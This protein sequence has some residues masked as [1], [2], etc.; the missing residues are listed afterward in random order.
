MANNMLEG[1]AL[2]TPRRTP[3][4]A[5]VTKCS[6][7][8]HQAG[9]SVGFNHTIAHAIHSMTLE[10]LHLFHPQATATNGIPTVN[11]DTNTGGIVDDAPEVVFSLHSG[12][13]VTPTMKG[14]N[15]LFSNLG[16]GTDGY[17]DAWSPVER[18]VHDFHMRDLW[19]AVHGI[20]ASRV[21]SHPPS[22][23]VCTCLLDTEHNGIRAAVQWVADQYKR[24]TPITLLG[25]SIP[26]LTD[27]A[28]WSI[29]R[30]R[31]THYYDEQS[32][33]DAATYMHC[34][35]WANLH[36]PEPVV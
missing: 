34:R 22:E 13:F 7:A 28:S 18:I 29:W 17:S 19:H 4:S 6:A 24:W 1:M 27:K 36:G 16:K 32:L 5:N 9:L 8:Y 23:S 35:I 15:E 21:L 33:F 10:G 2:S 3:G 14:I 30:K 25:R 20:Y 31:I 11:R 26:K 12:G